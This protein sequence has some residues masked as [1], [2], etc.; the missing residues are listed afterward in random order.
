MMKYLQVLVLKYELNN[1]QRSRD[2]VR[3]DSEDSE[4]ELAVESV[5]EK[6]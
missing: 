6:K 4:S 3:R 2:E 1:I 5:E